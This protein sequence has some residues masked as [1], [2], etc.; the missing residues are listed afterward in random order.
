MASV[1]TS[2]ILLWIFASLLQGCGT[3]VGK[4]ISGLATV[5][6][7]IVDKFGEEV[8]VQQSGFQGS[9]SIIVTFINSSL[10]DKTEQLRAAR[11]LET[12]QIVK[13]HYASIVEINRIVINFVRY[14]SRFLVFHYTQGLGS[15]GFDRDAK[16][17]SSTANNPV[18]EAS[19]LNPSARYSTAQ[20]KTEISQLVQLE[21][22]PTSG[23]TMFPHFSVRGDA[24]KAPSQP[25]EQVTF[26]FASYSPAGN[27]SNETKLT[28]HVDKELAVERKVSFSRSRVADGQVAEFLFLPM[29]YET[30]LRIGNATNVIIAIGSHK[31]TLKRED[32]VAMRNMNAY[33]RRQ[34]TLRPQ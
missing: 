23:V 1:R 3:K 24:N 21:G 14:E 8:Q 13:N 27:F 15:Y 2:L 30:F 22:V 34:P 20:D 5:H 11:A 4:T 16:P 25:P 9:A 19:H 7:A 12:A 6:A 33:V 17:L 18:F 31:Y 10:N 29:K 26:D 28:I 32:L